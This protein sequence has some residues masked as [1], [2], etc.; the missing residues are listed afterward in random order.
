MVARPRRA[1]FMSW[2]SLPGWYEAGIDRS[3]VIGGKPLD[4]MRAIIRDYSR[5]GDLIC[6]PCAGGATTLI[7]AAIEGRRSV[8]A[9][10]DPKTH[11]LAMKRIKAGHTP[12]L[13]PG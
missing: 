13:F 7:A 9:E 5:P 8:G 10:M 1:S 2:G 4:L 12:S 3:G 11:A 6:D